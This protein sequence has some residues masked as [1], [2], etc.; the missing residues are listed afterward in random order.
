MQQ[1][2]IVLSTL[3]ELIRR[4]IFCKVHLYPE[5]LEVYDKYNEAKDKN[6]YNLIMATFCRKS[7]KTYTTVSIAFEECIKNPGFSV[8]CIAPTR[9][10]IKLF[11]VPVVNEVLDFFPPD[12]RPQKIYNKWIFPNGSTFE[13]FGADYKDGDGLRGPKADLVIIDEAGFM[14]VDLEYFILSVVNPII[15]LKNGKIF[16]VST[17]P[18]SI[19]HKYYNYAM[20]AE[21][22]GRHI[23]RTI[24]E[25]TNYKDNPKKIEKIAKQSGGVD[26]IH[27]RREYLCEFITDP[28]ARIIPEYN[29]SYHPS[30][31]KYMPA[32]PEKIQPYMCIDFGFKHNTGIIFGYFHPVLGK[33]V[34]EDELWLKGKSTGEIARLIKEKEYELYGDFLKKHP[35]IRMR[36]FGDNNHQLCYDLTKDHGVAIAPIRKISLDATVSS[37]RNRINSHYVIGHKC[38]ALK[39]QL[40]NGIWDENRK[41][42]EESAAMEKDHEEEDMIGHNDNIAA[43]M[44]LNRYI[45]WRQDL[46]TI[47]PINPETT[48]SRPMVVKKSQEY[49]SIFKVRKY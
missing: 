46:G 1:N 23:K 27:F 31:E 28:S 18:K 11:I 34:I 21:K 40:L 44:Y 24:Y 26:S 32:R 30:E 48:V 20:Q 16:M 33:G 15:E 19:A 10:Q 29:D 42:F 7:G 13:V 38:K 8:F 39:F 17:P 35:E 5:Q 25:V 4:G 45:D 22:E 14:K 3:R 37:L 49:K 41:K 36:R 6:D 12:L 43:L 9:E 47:K 2:G